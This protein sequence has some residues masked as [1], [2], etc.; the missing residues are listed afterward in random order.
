MFPFVNGAEGNPSVLPVRN[1][2]VEINVR[3]LPQDAR[4]EG[5]DNSSAKCRLKIEKKFPLWKVS[6]FDIANRFAPLAPQWLT[7]ILFGL[8]C[9]LG[10]VFA[11]TG[12]DVVAA[13]AGPYAL[14]YPTVLIA[15]LFG[16]WQAGLVAWATSFLYS[17]YYV[18]P[19]PSSFAFAV[20]GDGARTIVNGLVVL[21]ILVFAEIFRRAV[22]EANAQRDR[23]IEARGLML[24]EIDHRMRNNFAIVASF[25]AMQVRGASTPEAKDMLAAAS[26]RLHSFAAAH[27]SLYKT[28]SGI[29]MAS[30]IDMSSYLGEITEHL[31]QALFD[32]DSVRVR[33]DVR[34][35]RL[36]R[37]KAATIG[38]MVN[39]LVTNA[40]KHAFDG[41]DGGEV[42]IFFDDDGA[43]WRLMVADNGCGTKAS[44][45]TSEDGLGAALIEAFAQKI[46]GVVRRENGQAG[47][48]VVVTGAI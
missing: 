46:G 48:R 14:A 43:N 18:L 22:R 23:E 28:Y 35:S 1:F 16:R 24:R 11:R 30:L 31:K 42:Q 29:E 8:A 4:N 27:R 47:T 6:D 39:E 34:D 26:G 40:A 20:E 41:R 33:L 44:A 25:L 36:P 45:P 19:A 15:T 38:L 12:V 2:G 32:A 10:G 3:I 5:G 9:T 13:A 37:E 21:V 7:Q 17:W